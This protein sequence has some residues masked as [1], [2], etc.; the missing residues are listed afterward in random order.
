MTPTPAALA[1]G[2]ALL[3]ALGGAQ[4][5]CGQAPGSPPASERPRARS[6]PPRVE[7]GPWQVVDPEADRALEGHTLYHQGP[8]P[9][10]LQKR[11]PGPVR[12]AGGAFR[13][14]VAIVQVVLSPE[15]TIARARVLRAPEVEG[16]LEAL[17]ESL[18]NWR[19]E[20]ARLKGEPVAVYYNLTVP[21]VG[22]APP[23]AE[24]P[25]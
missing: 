2:L 23:G 25:G 19:F 20:P 13:E 16:V 18:R 7:P 12:V 8:E 17:V 3:L 4:T 9:P 15:G 11:E 6:V 24:P 5:G 22:E 1:F 10:T 14:G 21:V